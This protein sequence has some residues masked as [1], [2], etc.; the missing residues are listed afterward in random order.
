VTNLKRSQRE[1]LEHVDMPTFRTW[2]LFMSGQHIALR[3]DR[4]MFANYY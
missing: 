3:L 4:Q 1:V 2:H